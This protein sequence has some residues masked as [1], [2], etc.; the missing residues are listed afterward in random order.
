MFRAFTDL[1]LEPADTVIVSGI[2]CSSRL[3][4]FVSTYGYHGV[5][6]RA[7]PTATGIKIANPDL[8][9]VV[10]GGDGDGLAIGAAHFTHTCRRNVDITYIM[11][12]NFI[13]GLTKGQ[14]SPTTHPGHSTKSTPEGPLEIPLDPSVFAITFGATYVARCFSA[15][16]AETA[17]IMAEAIKHKGFSFVQV[18]SP[19]KTFYDTQ[20]LCRETTAPLGEA[21]YDPSDHQAAIAAA[22]NTDPIYLGVLFNSDQPP[23]VE[24]QPLS[25]LPERAERME[26]LDKVF[27]KYV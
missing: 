26:R 9:V 13:Y 23:H 12:D 15:Q 5:H 8:N 19:C 21:V 17:N 18:L 7:L 11:M 24:G 27:S 14:A 22:M 2:G 4:Y 6:G 20:Q 1:E 25:S 3:P 16:P 10:A